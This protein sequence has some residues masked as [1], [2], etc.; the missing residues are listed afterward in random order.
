MGGN[1]TKQVRQ[2]TTEPA[3]VVQQL[4]RQHPLV[5]ALGGS[6]VAQRVALLERQAPELVQAAKDEADAPVEY[7]GIAALPPGAMYYQDANGTGWVMAPATTPDD[8]VMPKQ[9]AEVQRRLAPVMATGRTY[10]A[11]EIERERATEIRALHGQ[12]LSPAEATELVGPI[13]PPAESVAHGER[14]A[15]CSKQ[16]TTGLQRTGKAVATVIV[17]AVAIPIAAAAALAAPAAM[18]DP[19]ILVALPA[20]SERPGAPAAWFKAAEWVW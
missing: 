14:M 7:L 6:D 19:I 8:A 9:V 4:L 10:V 3:E 15:L 18:V 5:P 1:M 2:Q 20:A 13:P 11:H 16:I 17:G 12:E